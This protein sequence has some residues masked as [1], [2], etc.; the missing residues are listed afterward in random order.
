MSTTHIE[1]P[2]SRAIAKQLLS[3]SKEPDNQPFIVQEEGCLAGLVQYTQHDDIEV[4]L[5]STR[6]LQFLSSHPANKATMKEFPNLV[7]NLLSAVSRANEH[8]KIKEFVYETLDNLNV[9]FK[10]EDQSF[11]EE[12]EYD[13]ENQPHLANTNTTTQKGASKPGKSDSKFGS[14]KPARPQGAFRTI[15]FN[16]P[17]V[18]DR[19]FRHDIEMAALQVEGVIS[20]TVN[21]DKEHLLIGTRDE[22]DEIVKSVVAELAGD[23]LSVKVVVPRKAAQ[24][25]E[26]HNEEAG[27]DDDYPD[28]LEESDYET[29]EDERQETV[30]RTGFSS[31]EARLEQQR[32][33]EEARNADKSS[34]LIG[35]VSGML[36]GASSW[37][38][39]Y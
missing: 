18:G 29:D 32:K 28:Y 30:A 20:V 35:K 34:R 14:K 17:G 9:S 33:E 36:S 7:S 37:L 13:T 15:T 4:V 38:L 26:D 21:V 16:V 23:G 19:A 22:G 11:D 39:G 3:L 1:V 24:E 5:I 2:N 31:L 10:R 6:A 12:E 25:A 8:G 27:Y